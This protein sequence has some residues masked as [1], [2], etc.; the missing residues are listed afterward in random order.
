[1]SADEPASLLAA[2]P[3]SAGAGGGAAAASGCSC[4]LGVIR[5][6]ATGASTRS[7]AARA[8]PVTASGCSGCGVTRG[9]GCRRS[10]SGAGAGRGCPAILPRQLRTGL[11]DRL[12][13]RPHR[14]RPPAEDPDRHRRAHPRSAR[15]TCRAQ[16][17]R[18]RHR[19]HARADRR[20]ARA[21]TEADPLRQR[22]RVR[23]ANRCETGAAS[24]TPAPATSSPARPG[25][26]RSSNPSTATSAASCS[27][28]KA[29]TACFEAQLLL[30]DWRLEY[31]HYRPH[32][33]LNYMTP[34]EYARRWRTD[35]QPELS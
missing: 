11:G 8:G 6:T 19:Q 18:R 25:R 14:R 30:D 17:G 35:N 16:D 7:C 33:S 20:A 21:S 34:A 22:A 32:Q 3:A 15:N 26:I 12:R 27:R 5:A 23:L 10:R 29:S 1:M 9:C 4:S 28:W 31:N 2:L 24:T 13:Q